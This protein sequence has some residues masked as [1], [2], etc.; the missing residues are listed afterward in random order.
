MNRLAAIIFAALALM[1][2]TSTLR[3]EPPMPQPTLE[4][5]R[6]ILRAWFLDYDFAGDVPPDEAKSNLE[7]FRKHYLDVPLTRALNARTAPHE[8]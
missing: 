5:G 3:K 4:E 6:R 1:S 2:C 8:D 7:W